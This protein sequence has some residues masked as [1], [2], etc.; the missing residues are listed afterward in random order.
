MCLVDVNFEQSTGFKPFKQ[1]HIDQAAKFKTYLFQAKNGRGQPLSH[2]IVDATLTLVRNFF[3]WLAGQSGYKRVLPYSDARYFNSKHKSA[4][5]AHTANDDTLSSLLLATVRADSALRGV[6]K[7]L[8][9]GRHLAQVD[10]H[11]RAI[12]TYGLFQHQLPE[13]NICRRFWYMPKEVRKKI[14]MSR[15]HENAALPQA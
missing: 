3:L 14:N 12:D 10:R 6:V 2:L 9:G 11:L 1:F 13:Q 15:V 8:I 5:I 4:R 7:R